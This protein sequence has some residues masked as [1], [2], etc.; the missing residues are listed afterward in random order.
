MY[1][2][3]KNSSAFTLLG[4]GLKSTKQYPLVEQP[5]D[6]V[7]GCCAKQQ[8]KLHL[9]SPVWNM[10]MH[11][12]HCVHSAADFLTWSRARENSAVLCDAKQRPNQVHWGLAHVMQKYRRKESWFS[13]GLA[14]QAVLQH[15]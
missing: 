6:E 15:S 9:I 2:L 10:I 1:K 12:G 4:L 5:L 3:E 11:T 8:R 7:L 13:A 14:S